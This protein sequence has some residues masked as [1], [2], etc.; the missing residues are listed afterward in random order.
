MSDKPIRE[1][2][3]IRTDCARKLA[4]V[5]ISGMFSAILGCLLDEDWAEPRIE[6]LQITPDRGI[7]ARVVGEAGFNLFLGAEVDLIRNIHGVATIAE[8][9]GD[10]VGYLVGRVAEIK[11][12]R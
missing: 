1:P 4:E 5:Q 12:I 8:L 11:G 10:E 9:D 2:N 6:E 7:L 3:E